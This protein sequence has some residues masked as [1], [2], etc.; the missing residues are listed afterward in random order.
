MR[1]T[2][3]I[4]NDILHEAA[5]ALLK[6]D[7][8]KPMLTAIQEYNRTLH[9]TVK[10][11]LLN[12]AYFRAIELAKRDAGAAVR[13]RETI[14]LSIH[15][16]PEEK[17][18]R[19]GSN[20]GIQFIETYRVEIQNVLDTWRYDLDTT[21]RGV[22]VS[23]PFIGYGVHEDYF[24]I[25]GS[26]KLVEVINA[27]RKKRDESIETFGELIKDLANVINAAG[28][29]KTLEKNAPALTRFIPYDGSGVPGVTMCSTALVNALDAIK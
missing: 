15:T 17:L 1:L 25:I 18:Y 10:V 22:N 9:E 8:G 2:K 4:K 16:N 14:L 26:K 21:Q 12:D 29:T 19:W 27:I 28:S 3:A 6:S 13:N 23:I 11:H 7:T 20:Q 24:Q 5:V